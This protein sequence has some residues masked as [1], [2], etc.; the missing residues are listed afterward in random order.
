MSS[1]IKKFK[2]ID[3]NLE[4]YFFIIQSKLIFFVLIEL[5]YNQDWNFGFM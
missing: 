2:N 1:I 5:F 3:L 4:N